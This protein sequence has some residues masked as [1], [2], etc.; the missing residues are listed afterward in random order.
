RVPEGPGSA[1]LPSRAG[2]RGLSAGL[3]EGGET[4]GRR[5]FTAWRRDGLASYEDRHDDMAGDATSRLSPHLHFG[6][7]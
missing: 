2:T 6:T 1:A 4:E 3:A 7:L 5:L